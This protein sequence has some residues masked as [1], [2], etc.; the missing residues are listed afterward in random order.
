[1]TREQLRL[2]AAPEIVV[3]D[4]VDACLTALRLAL[5]AEHPLLA[6]DLAAGEGPPVQH[7][8]RVVLRHADR[9]RRSLD[10]YRR[11]VDA[12]LQTPDDPDPF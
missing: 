1:M 10:A 2:I 3:V 5:R 8:A 6:N 7:R 9:L 11:K 12:V 4:L